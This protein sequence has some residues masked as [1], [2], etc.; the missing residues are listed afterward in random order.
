[1]VLPFQRVRLSGFSVRVKAEISPQALLT[2]SIAHT[3]RLG[4]SG[5]YPC[6]IVERAQPLE[7]L[8]AGK[9]DAFVADDRDESFMKALDKSGFIDAA[10]KTAK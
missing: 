10:Y 1:M 2:P 5:I 6:I 8:K 9:A 7:D 3:S 4:G